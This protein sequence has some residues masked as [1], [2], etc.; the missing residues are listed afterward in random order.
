M[1]APVVVAASGAARTIAVFGESFS[2]VLRRG[3]FHELDCVSARDCKGPHELLALNMKVEDLKFG[4][5]CRLQRFGWPTEWTGVNIAQDDDGAFDFLAEER[6][7]I[8]SDG[9]SN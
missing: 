9:F 3:I 1:S 5:N 7:D 2:G 4:W 6:F 8:E